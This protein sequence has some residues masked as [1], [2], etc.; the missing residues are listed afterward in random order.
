[1]PKKTPQAYDFITSRIETI[2][3]L[4]PSL[5]DKN[6]AYIFNA[7]VVKSTFYKNPYYD[8]TD[9]DINDI[10]VDGRGDGGAD[11]LLFDPGSEAS[12]L[13]IGQAKFHQSIDSDKCNAA[14]NKMVDFYISMTNGNYQNVKPEVQQRYLALEGD[15]GDES[16]VLFFLFVSAPQ[17]RISID[18]LKQ[19]FYSKLSDHNKYELRV[20]FD[21]DIV[22]EIKEAESRKPA[23]EYGEIRIDRA[24][25]KIDYNNMA[26]MVNVSAF[27]IKKLYAQHQIN[28][29]AR[30]LRYHVAGTS[31]DKAIEE[32]IDN[33]PEL[34]WLKNNGITIICD[35]YEFDGNNVKLTNFSIVNGGQTTYKIS[36]S[37]QISKE[38]DLYLPCK[39]VKIIGKTD[40]ERDDFCLEIA[41]ATNSQ[42]PIKPSDLKANAPEQRRF[43]V[44]MRNEGIFYQTKRGEEVPTAYKTK[45]LHS[46][47]TEI[48]KLCLSAILQMPCT[49]R[50]KPSTIYKED[51]YYDFI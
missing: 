45:Y 33:T 38:Y 13:I 30:N 37:K 44:A 39:I 22:E 47:I 4:Y 29:L 24:E 26:I 18:K 14:I 7:L 34:F 3:E 19:T 46:D 27:S 28:L 10:I 5:Q 42:K 49:S 25:N 21:S 6:P 1:M 40:E 8:L 11:V 20:L 23:V 51:K 43:A 15:M 50:N 16:R 48:G 35:E 41:K 2:K 9:Q 36:K 32:S 12:D 31:V 17:K